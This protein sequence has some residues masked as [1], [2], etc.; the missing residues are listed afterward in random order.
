MAVMNDLNEQNVF[1]VEDLGIINMIIDGY[2]SLYHSNNIQYTERA[3]R[4]SFIHPQTNTLYSNRA[5]RTKI[6]T[7]Y[8]LRNGNRS[9]FSEN[10]MFQLIEPTSNDRYFKLKINENKNYK[11]KYYF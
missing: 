5:D 1:E 3:S 8:I 6:I 7:D 10:T 4:P 11:I 2:K 9:S